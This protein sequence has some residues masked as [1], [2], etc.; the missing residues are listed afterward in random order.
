MIL[1]HN[2]LKYKINIIIHEGIKEILYK[3]LRITGNNLGNLENEF[4]LFMKAMQ[5]T[6]KV[7]DFAVIIVY[8]DLF[9]RFEGKI[10][11]SLINTVNMSE[12]DTKKYEDIIVFY[13]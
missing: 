5:K 4:N 10:A 3:G 6:N 13:F 8:D 2:E 11:Y 1:D 12:E 7:Y 9:N